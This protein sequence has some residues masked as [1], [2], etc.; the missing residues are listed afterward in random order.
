MAYSDFTLREA[1]SRFGL[2]LADVPDLM[3]HVPPVEPSPLLKALVPVFL[4]LAVAV[5]NEKARSEWLVAPILGAVRDQ[6]QNRFSLFSGIEFNVEPAAGL[7]GRC[8]FL[9]SASPEQL[10]L[11]TPVAAIAE[12]KNDDIKSGQGQ[13]VAGMV[14]AARFNARDGQPDRPV[15]GVVTSGTVWQFLRL[16]GD[17]LSADL[18]QHYINDLPKLVGIIAHI[19][20]VA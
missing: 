17:S 5:D 11:R 14:A 13:C 4:P 10:L 12:A 8:D 19:A 9:L 15:Y 7:S 2:A 18:R 16:D 6:F 20:G 3:G 1:V